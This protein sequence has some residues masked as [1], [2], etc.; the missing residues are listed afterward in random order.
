MNRLKNLVIIAT[1]FTLIGFACTPTGTTP[2][3]S[4]L[5]N[6]VKRSAFDGNGIAGAVSF[7]I[8]DTAY[9]GTGF[10]GIVRFNDFWSY[11]PTTDSWSQRALMPIGAGKRNSAV[12]F[13]AAGKGYI[14]TGYDGINRLQDNWEFNP[15][16]NTWAQK[17]NLPDPI[18]GSA[19]SG[20]RYGA[21]GFGI[22]GKGYVCSGYT[23]THTKDLWE[24]NPGTDA[25]TTKPSM[26][27]SDKRT[28]AIALVHN[29]KAYIVSGTNN[30][31]VVTEVAMYDP[32]TSTWTKKRD[33]AN[34]TSETFDD[35]YTS[36]VRTNAVGFVIGSKGYIATGENG[37]NIKPT[38]EYDF[39]T[40]LW[41]L[42]T[43][44]ER[45]ER[46]AAVGFAVKGKGYVTLGRN[47]TFYF[48]NL[49]EFK[50]ND[51]YNAND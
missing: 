48:D 31:S 36:I 32:G 46:N 22:L 50:P 23:G 41:T 21:V 29:D 25:W 4:V 6:W 3:T 11:D 24:Y 5:G 43:S 9:V 45:S 38:W 49:D 2:E 42:K 34:L 44:Y 30:G 8:G 40:D 20:A 10:D 12:A 28:G 15:L 26:N 27:T 7:V 51:T 37:F 17:A 35:A 19:G 1:S 33:I 18:N 39:A 47:S 13:A 16:T 14:T